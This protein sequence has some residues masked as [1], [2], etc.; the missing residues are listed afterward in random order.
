MDKIFAD[1][2]N[3]KISQF[4]NLI[5]KV[6]VINPYYADLKKKLGFDEKVD[7]LL[8]IY[9]SLPVLKKKD[10]IDIG[11]FY[12]SRTSENVFEEITSGSSGQ[13]L[14]CKKT[15]YERMQLAYQIWLRRRKLDAEV[16]IDNFVDLFS[17]EVEDIIGRFYDVNES[18]VAENFYKIM[19]LNPRW[20]SGPISLIH[21]FTTMIL[22]GKL[23][24]LNSGTLKFI[25]LTGEFNNSNQVNEIKQVF[26]CNVV[27]HYGTRETWCIAY[28][29]LNGEM[30]VQSNMLVE[31]QK[32]GSKSKLLLT[33]LVNT[34]MPFIK[35]DVGDYGRLAQSH[36]GCGDSS[37]TLELNGGRVTDII[38]GSD[39]LGNY[40]FDQ[41]IWE[42]CVACKMPICQIQVEQT[43]FFLFI[44]YIVRGIEYDIVVEDIILKRLRSEIGENASVTFKYVSKLKPLRNGKVRKFY[45]FIE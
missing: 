41:I 10:I 3:K 30:H 2:F 36:C 11:D 42:A 1:D 33:S 35:Y 18:K 23:E 44:I 25:E 37:V 45:P 6:T 7:D 26:N 4:K 17:D 28:T 8:K 14:E 15:S 5:S 20:L 22:Q 21:R 19:S 39:I 40:F 27:D 16:N 38:T 9:E 31:S 12:Y 32:V 24:Y 34:Y 29:C 43:G 13:V